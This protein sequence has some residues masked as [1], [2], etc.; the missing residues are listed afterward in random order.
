MS[1]KALCHE[2]PSQGKLRLY[3]D[4]AGGLGDSLYRQ[5]AMYEE[6]EAQRFS[7]WLREQNIGMENKVCLLRMNIEGAEYDVVKDLVESGLATHISGFYGMWDDVSKI[8]KHRDAEFRSFL[9]RHQIWPLTFNG[10]DMQWP[11]RLRCIEYDINTSV[12]AGLKKLS[13]EGPRD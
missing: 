5:G 8:D 10:R 2:V 13:K 7:D 6:V 12:Q 11:L 9:S 3:K 4:S 1:H